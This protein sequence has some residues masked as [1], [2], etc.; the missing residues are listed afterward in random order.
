MVVRIPDRAVERQ[1][2]DRHSQEGHPE[3]RPRPAEP[4]V[5]FARH[6][7]PGVRPRQG[8][9]AGQAPRVRGDALQLPARRGQQQRRL[10]DQDGPLLVLLRRRNHVD[11]RRLL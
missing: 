11:S 2:V 1:Q 9:R 6:A 5:V 4:G 8:L 10:P 3:R 7:R